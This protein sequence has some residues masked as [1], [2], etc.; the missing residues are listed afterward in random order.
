MFMSL[1][2]GLFM[3]PE[4]NLNNGHLAQLVLLVII[5]PDD[6]KTKMLDFL[7]LNIPA[8]GGRKHACV[9]Y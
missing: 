1:G 7:L 2:S 4:K 5:V 9:R 6:T 8:V 3:I